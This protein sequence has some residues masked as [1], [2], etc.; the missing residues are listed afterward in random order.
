MD[1]TAG[2]GIFSFA[3][4]LYSPVMLAFHV[5]KKSCIYIG[6]FCGASYGVALGPGYLH[7]R[8]CFSL[9]VGRCAVCRMNNVHLRFVSR[10]VVEVIVFLFYFIFFVSFF[11]PF[12]FP[13]S[14][15]DFWREIVEWMAILLSLR[16]WWRRGAY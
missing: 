3:F 9:H 10:Y 12:S 6:F 13:F 14:V 2:I 8:T 7:V 11:F 1:V 15:F 16:S 5:S 4:L